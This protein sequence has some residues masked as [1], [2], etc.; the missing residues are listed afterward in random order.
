[1]TAGA[2]NNVAALSNQ[3]GAALSQLGNL[4][5]AIPGVTGGGGT[6]AATGA[7]AAAAT[8]N[9]Q[10]TATVKTLQGVNMQGAA[11]PVLK[12]EA[13]SEYRLATPTGKAEKVTVR[14]T[15]E[16]GQVVSEKTLLFDAQ[17]NNVRNFEIADRQTIKVDLDR[18]QGIATGINNLSRVIAGRQERLK[19]L[20][21]ALAQDSNE[22]GST[23]QVD[24]QRLVQEQQVTEH[25]SNMNH[26][27]YE[28]VQN[29]I[30]IWLR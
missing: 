10:T 9:T 30:Q 12:D 17:G 23:N 8:A 6:A 11:T 26:K 15:N 19:S 22:N 28:S 24:I 3:V 25:L 20:T 1:M 13:K 2:T 29:A 16:Q 7:N 14:E 21:E 4:G 18:R 27:I 5:V